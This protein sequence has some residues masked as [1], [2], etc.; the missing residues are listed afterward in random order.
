[1]ATKLKADGN[2]AYSKRKFTEAAKLYSRAIEVTAK[3]EPVF[4]SNR[5]A[6][7]C[8]WRRL[9]STCS[10]FIDAEGY[11]NYE[12]PEYEKVVE[13][14]DEALKLD[15]MYVK[16]LNRRA[17]ALEY[18]GRL[19]EALRGPCQCVL[20]AIPSELSMYGLQ[21]SLLLQS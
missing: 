4:Y 10:H 12:K 2:A 17:N 20:V 19:E 16:A 8:C 15:S 6:C 1:M 5:A 7:E 13:D 21:I 9:E 14:C 11:M 3:P 18:L